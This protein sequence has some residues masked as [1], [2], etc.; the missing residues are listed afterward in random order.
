MP[1][2]ISSNIAEVDYDENTCTV[3]VL[4]HS[5]DKYEFY[6]VPKGIY[7]RMLTAKSV[8]KYFNLYIKEAGYEYSK[9]YAIPEQKKF[10]KV[11]D[12]ELAL[13]LKEYILLLISNGYATIIEIEG[14]GK[15]S[16]VIS[17]EMTKL[18]LEK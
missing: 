12:K 10:E 13:K 16:I 4:F 9:I 14:M 6:R 2:V 8:G 5:G 3:T 11:K 15:E 17:S 7:D 1:K 18:I